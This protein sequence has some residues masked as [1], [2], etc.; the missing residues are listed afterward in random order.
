MLSIQKVLDHSSAAC[1]QPEH[2]PGQTVHRK[3]WSSP[4][5]KRLQCYQ[6]SRSLHWTGEAKVLSR[7]K[8]KRFLYRFALLF[9]HE[10]K[11]NMNSRT[12]PQPSFL[13]LH[14]SSETAISCFLL[15]WQ[16]FLSFN[17]YYYFLKFYSLSSS[18]QWEGSQ[19]AYNNFRTKF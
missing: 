16:S 6:H 5:N 4:Q 14:F 13:S 3:H 8:E 11:Q 9:V 15:W 1:K 2:L 7:D 10:Y 12:Q 18:S 19:G 17:Y